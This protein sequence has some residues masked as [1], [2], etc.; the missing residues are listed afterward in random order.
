[1]EAATIFIAFVIFCVDLTLAIRTRS[2]L[3]LAIAYA[4]PLIELSLVG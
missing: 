3:R 4:H 2:D 1:L